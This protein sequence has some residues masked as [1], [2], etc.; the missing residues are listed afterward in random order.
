MVA[1]IPQIYEN[2]Y[3]LKDLLASFLY[4]MILS[5]RLL[6]RYEYIVLFTCTSR[7]TSLQHFIQ[8]VLFLCDV[9][10]HRINSHDQSRSYVEK[11]HSETGFLKIRRKC[12]PK[13]ISYRHV[14]NR[15]LPKYSYF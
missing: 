6:K 8:L 2:R 11:S 10:F 3:I 7:P 13:V 12:R 4:A 1:R 14:Y 5:C 15:Y 9:H